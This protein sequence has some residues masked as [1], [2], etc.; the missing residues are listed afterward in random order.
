MVGRRW[1][2]V[3]GRQQSAFS[4]QFRIHYSAFSQSLNHPLTQ[5]FTIQNSL[6]IIQHSSP[7]LSPDFFPVL[8]FGLTRCLSS[9]S[10]GSIG[11]PPIHAE[12]RPL[13]EKY[14]VTWAYWLGLASTA[15]A[16][17]LRSLAASG[18]LTGV[19]VHRGQ[20]IGYLSFYRGALLFFL[21]AIATASYTWVRG[22]APR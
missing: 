22:Q 19:V 11:K 16:L 14:I 7:L 10:I 15:I 1:Q 18:V 6:F 20:T 3:G 8:Y 9:R 12:R 13:V 21:I 5:F 2:I 17:V 4:F